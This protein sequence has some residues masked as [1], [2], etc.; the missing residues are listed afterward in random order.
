MASTIC[1][2]CG[3]VCEVIFRWHRKDENTGKTIKA[4]KRPFPIT[5]CSCSSSRKNA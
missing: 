5:L 4:S 1:K 2:K 3:N